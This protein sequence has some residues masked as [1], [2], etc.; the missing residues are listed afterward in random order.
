M[1]GIPIYGGSPQEGDL[2]EVTLA[3][4]VEAL[5]VRHV[6]TVEYRT[7]DYEVSRQRIQGQVTHSLLPHARSLFILL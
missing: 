7:D 3:I 2:R 4:D 6:R 5:E 1:L